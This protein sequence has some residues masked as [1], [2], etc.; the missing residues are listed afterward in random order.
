MRP[1]DYLILTASFA[2]APAYLCRL[3]V[4]RVGWHQTAVVL[5]H[6][7]LFVGCIVAGYH[8]FDGRGALGDVVSLCVACL[9]IAVSYPTWRSGRPPKHVIRERT[10]HSPEMDLQPTT[11]GR[12]KR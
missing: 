8:A 5:F 10:E 2:L 6:A 12:S 11:I 7:L 1:I 3:N 4:L 9:W